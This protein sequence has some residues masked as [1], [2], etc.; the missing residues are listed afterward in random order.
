[1]KRKLS[2]ISF[3]VLL[4]FSGTSCTDYLTLKPESEIVLENYWQTESDVESV[5]A[6]CYRGLTEDAVISRMIVWGEL[7][8]DNMVA[9]T[10]F[11]TVRYDMQRI[12]DG[13]LIPSK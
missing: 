2:I 3:V 9:G 8:S 6:A 4:L 1:M 11:P 10:G 5:L 12:L 7:R 13:N